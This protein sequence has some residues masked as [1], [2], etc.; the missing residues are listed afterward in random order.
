MR[1]RP[2]ID[3]IRSITPNGKF[4]I[5]TN[6]TLD[7]GLETMVFPM[8][9]DGHVSDW[10]EVDTANYPTPEQAIHGHARMLAKWTRTE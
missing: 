8:G 10:A 3:Q 6:D 2:E 9:E 4:F 7:H 5:S 1:F